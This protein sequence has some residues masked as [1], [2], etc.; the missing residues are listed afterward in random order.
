MGEPTPEQPSQPADPQLSDERL[1][2]LYR[3]GQTHVDGQDI[4]AVL[5]R[6][7]QRELYHFLVRFTGDPSLAEDLFQET[8]L[9]VHLSIDTFDTSRRFRPWLFTVATNKARDYMRRTS[10]RS[11]LS[12]SAERTGSEEEGAGRALIDLLRDQAPQPTESAEQTETRQLVRQAVQSMPEH[13]REILLL[14]YFQ[15]MSYKQIAQML[16]VPLGTVKSRLHQAVATFAQLWRHQREQ[17][18]SEAP[19]TPGSTPPSQR[20]PRGRTGSET[21]G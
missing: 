11:M 18:E 20:D 8:F 5:A 3:Q 1:I 17:A 9:Q 15:Q 7:Y 12:L 21:Q 16:G 14:A 6:R 13:L 4:F 10:H 2:E 19:T